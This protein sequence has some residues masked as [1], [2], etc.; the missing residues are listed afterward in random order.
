[1]EYGLSILSTDILFIRA[2]PIMLL[3]YEFILRSPLNDLS[4]EH[5]VTGIDPRMLA[6]DENTGNK[7]TRS[8]SWID[9]RT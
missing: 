2:C 8:D 3:R 5:D 9:S 6:T 7:V 1:M 4:A